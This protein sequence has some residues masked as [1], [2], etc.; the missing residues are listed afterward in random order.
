MLSDAIFDKKLIDYTLSEPFYSEYIAVFQFSDFRFLDLVKN[1]ARIQVSFD[2][3]SM[4]THSIDTKFILWQAR[5]QIYSLQMSMPVLMH[6]VLPIIV[7]R[8]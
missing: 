7:F 3:H 8:L 5:L 1:D 4:N 2:F 6:Q